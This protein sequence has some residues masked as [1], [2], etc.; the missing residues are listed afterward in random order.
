MK[1]EAP[2]LDSM[3]LSAL[4]PWGQEYGFSKQ[5]LLT[6]LS[7]IIISFFFLFAGREKSLI[8]SKLQF[9]G[10]TCFSFI[11]NDIAKSIIGEN[12][13]KYIPIL[14]TCFFFILINNIY[15]MIPILQLPTFSHPGNAYIIAIIAYISWVSS[16]I[17]HHGF[18]GFLKHV[19]I[20]SGVPKP[21]L[22]LIAPIEFFSNLIVR[23]LT[24]SLR[25]FAT[26]FAGHLIIMVFAAG[27]KFMIVDINSFLGFMG[28]SLAI[29]LGVML[30]FLEVL[31]MML[32]AYVFTL[33]LAIYIQG[34]LSKD[35]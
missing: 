15:G 32:Q 33:L 29:F 31:I 24:H 1:F 30:Y 26:M 35:H 5:M 12:F 13:Q 22:L 14:F 3:H 21:L 17:K 18:L 7:T 11:R 25:L 8:P 4:Y 28:G 10:E 19:M 34:A 9:I 27:A 23:P 2:S 20:P 16:G 6:L